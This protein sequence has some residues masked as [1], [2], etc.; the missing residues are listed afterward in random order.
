MF[1]QAWA[2]VQSAL[3]IFLEC[4]YIVMCALSYVCGTGVL[5]PY[6]RN[7]PPIS[8][9]MQPRACN[10]SCH[11]CSHVLALSIS[12]LNKVLTLQY[13]KHKIKRTWQYTH[14]HERLRGH[15]AQTLTL[16]QTRAHKLLEGTLIKT[17]LELRPM[18]YYL[19]LNKEYCIKP[20]SC[21]FFT[22]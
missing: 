6:L 21:L 10:P 7:P 9:S 1:A 12:S 14:S 13:R 22:A 18:V 15:F 4:V 3:F 11:T 2:F 8:L 19:N 17:L 20:D 16:A 5:G